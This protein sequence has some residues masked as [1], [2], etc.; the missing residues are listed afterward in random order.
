MPD[1]G[2]GVTRS[3]FLERLTVVG[4][5]A[6]GTDGVATLAGGASSEAL[7]V[8]DMR[9]LNYVLRVEELKAAF[10]RQAS[11]ASQERIDRVEVEPKTVD[12]LRE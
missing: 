6:L 12:A 8:R 2:A 9:I 11:A 4:G 1:T 10:Y 3:G 5:T 7:T